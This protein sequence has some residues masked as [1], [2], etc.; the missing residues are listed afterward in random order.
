MKQKQRLAFNL[1]Q[2][3]ETSDWLGQL[4]DSEAYV[5]LEKNTHDISETCKRA[6]SLLALISAGGLPTS[7]LVNM[8]KELHSLDQAA[9]S[10]RQTSQWSFTTLE[11][12]ERQDLSP[13]ARGI[14]DRIQLHPD[15]WMAYEWN[16]H[17]T[18]RIIFL[19][20]LLQCSKAALEA[21]DLAEVEK[22]TL[23]NTVT[24]CI[25]TIQWLADEFLAT[26]P[27]SFGDVNHMGQP[28]DGKDG[29][30]RC[31]AI[32]GYLLL[33]PTRTAKDEKSATSMEQKERAQRVFERIREYT[34]MKDLL[35]DKSAI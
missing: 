12:S 4:N 6:R 7:T 26:V 34:G 15:V 24:E 19:Q 21:L 13:A 17:R 11:V 33:W 10:W 1:P 30:P 35:G 18:A 22:Q 32:G 8:I 25:L 2:T 29:P 5:R 27:Q 3:D 23:N 28:H 9:V 31:R 14:T 20:Q 16:Y